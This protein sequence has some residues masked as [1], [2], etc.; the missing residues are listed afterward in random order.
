MQP[1]DTPFTSW[2][3][4]ICVLIIILYIT[5]RTK[6]LYP[7]LLL[8]VLAFVWPKPY[9]YV[10]DG[11]SLRIR[12]PGSE[13]RCYGLDMVSKNNYHYPPEMESMPRIEKHTCYGWLTPSNKLI[14]MFQGLRR[15]PI[16][17]PFC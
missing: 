13:Q 3:I 16:Y 15:E 5:F 9:D 1:Y 6:K 7:L 17:C 14:D 8:L 12:G 4:A 10:P 11:T 2:L